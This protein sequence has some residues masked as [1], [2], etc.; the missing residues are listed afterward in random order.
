[1]LRQG[2]SMT[3]RIFISHSQTDHLWCDALMDKLTTC[4]VDLWYDRQGQYVGEQWL[5]KIQEELNSRDTF[6][7][8]ITLTDLGRKNERFLFRMKPGQDKD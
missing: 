1:M 6:L 3:L 2:A 5:W 4:D 8:M 7:V